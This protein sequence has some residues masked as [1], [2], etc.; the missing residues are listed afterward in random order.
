MK[1]IIL[2]KGKMLINIIKAAMDSNCEIAGILRYER[3]FVNPLQLFFNDFLKNTP[4]LT[5]I[6]KY[7]IPEIKAKS[8]NSQEFR[9]FILKS[10]ADLIIVGTWSEKICKQTFSMPKIGTINIHPSLLPRYRGPN[11]Y[12]QVIKRGEKKSGVTIH[13]MDENLDT[14]PILLQKEI[15]ILPNDTGKE[16]RERTY[17]ATRI[18]LKEFFAKIQKEVII[19]IKQNESRASYF[20]NI[21]EVEKMLDFRN[22]T[23]EELYATIRALHP[24]LP[25]YITIGNKFL[26][27]NPYKCSIINTQEKGCAGE[28]IAKDENKKSLTITCKCGR[29]LEME[30]LKLWGFFIRPFTKQFIK[31]IKIG[32]I[33]N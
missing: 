30:D 20:G 4:E 31:N 32:T 2:S 29:A 10:N 11:P 25:C 18:L 15:D 23:A 28:I 9:N 3:A 8:A 19:P 12:M 33:T 17:F 16:L 26:S 1:V 22:K 5:I 7:K 14:G 24:W 13:L 27:I 6:K 21:A